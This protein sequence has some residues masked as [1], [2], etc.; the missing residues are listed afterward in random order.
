MTSSLSFITWGDAKLP[1]LLCLHGFLG[2]KEDFSLL[3]PHLTK[4]FFCIAIDL[5]GFGN[6]SSI[7][8]KGGWEG[9]LK[10]LS[11]FINEQNFP[12]LSLLGYSLGGRIALS[13]IPLLRD[14]AEV[15]IVSSRLNLLPEEKLLQQKKMAQHVIDMENLSPEEFLRKWYA[16]PLFSTLKE[17]NLFDPLIQKR[18]FYDK[19]AAQYYLKELSPL[20]Q[21]SCLKILSKLK[22]GL[23]LYGEKDQNYADHYQKYQ[24]EYP[25][26]SFSW[27]EKSS[28]ALIEESPDQVSSAIFQFLGDPY[29]CSSNSGN[30][31]MDTGRFLHRYSL[32]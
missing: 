28:H 15:F 10:E 30:T 14:V 11:E 26:L 23:F 21:P 18:K 12:S 1:P 3:C 4:Q 7:L 29:G 25:H 31:K 9:L 16:Q 22:R 13:L 17:K 32:S 19:K 27:I 24:E 2:T 8:L 5:P 20:N 6:S